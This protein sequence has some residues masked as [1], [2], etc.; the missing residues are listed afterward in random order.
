MTGRGRR[1]TKPKA[2]SIDLSHIAQN[3]T[4]FWTDE[5]FEMGNGSGSPFLGRRYVSVIVG[6]TGKTAAYSTTKKRHPRLSTISARF[7]SRMSAGE[8][9][10]S[11]SILPTTRDDDD[12]ALYADDEK[13]QSSSSIGSPSS[14]SFHERRQPFLILNLNALL[15]DAFNSFNSPIEPIDQF[16]S[17]SDGGSVFDPPELPTFKVERRRESFLSLNSSSSNR[18]SFSF[19]AVPRNYP[20]FA[21]PRSPLSPSSYTQSSSSW[22]IDEGEGEAEEEEEMPVEASEDRDT[23]DWDAPARIDWRQFHVHLLQIANDTPPKS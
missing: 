6:S 15:I 11:P 16:S 2:K 23:C 19:P 7:F 3:R 14:P 10:L 5:Y 21:E 1:R 9:V 17:W 20:T 13:E 8:P 22:E 18:S 4:S 12:D